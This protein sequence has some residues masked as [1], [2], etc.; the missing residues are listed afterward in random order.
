MTAE[1]DSADARRA[2]KILKGVA[3]KG[4]KLTY[5][6]TAMFWAVIGG[7]VLTFY[8]SST[9][10]VFAVFGMAAVFYGLFVFRR[11]VW[12]AVRGAVRRR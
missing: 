3:R 11:L 9:L 10:N 7:A 6:L 2:G 12:S 8:V 4:E 5:H 1:S